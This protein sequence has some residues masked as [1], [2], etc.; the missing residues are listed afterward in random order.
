MPSCRRS[1]DIEVDDIGE[2]D[3]DQRRGV[4]CERADVVEGGGGGGGGECNESEGEG[5]EPPPDPLLG[6]VCRFSRNAPFDGL[7]ASGVQVDFT[8]FFPFVLSPS[9][10]VL[11]FI[12]SLAARGGEISAAGAPR[13]STMVAK[14]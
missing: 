7:R 10:D 11:E 5:E 8:G 1:R 9:K 6:R 12:D 4:T 13:R 14:R 3:D 2:L